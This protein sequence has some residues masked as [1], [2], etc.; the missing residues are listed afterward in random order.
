[1]YSDKTT[2]IPAD[3]DDLW[4]ILREQFELARMALLDSAVESEDEALGLIDNEETRQKQ[5]LKG[6]SAVVPYRGTSYEMDNRDHFLE[7]GCALLPYVEKALKTRKLTP[8]FVQQWSKLM[9]CHGFIASYLLDDSDPLVNKRAGHKTGKLRSKDAQR[10]WI[11]HIMV[12]LIEN[13]MKREQAEHMVVKH[14]EAALQLEELRGGFPVEWFM[15]I[16]SRG[17]L[18]AT[19]DFKHFSIKAMRKLMELPTDDIPP[20]PQIP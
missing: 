11:A 15:P 18:V 9:F 19:Y 17:E 8:E 20:I 12:P 1:M 2:R 6:L 14:V 7:M 5:R 16:V 4:T 10:K 13:G 3:E